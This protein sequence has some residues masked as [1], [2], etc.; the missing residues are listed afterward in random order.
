MTK[1]FQFR[2]YPTK[3]QKRE[4]FRQF[5]IHKNLYNFCLKERK[6][7]YEKTKKSPSG[8]DQI[9]ANVSKFK[10]NCNTSSLQQ[11][12]RR[13]DKSF[14]NFFRRVKQGQTPGFPRFKSRFDSIEF[15][16]GDG[17]RKKGDFT[18]VQHVG[19]IKTIFH[20]RFPEYSRVTISY[21]Q[22]RF[23]ASYSCD[24]IQG[25]SPKDGIVGIDFGFKTFV[26][27]SDGEK[28]Q[29]PKFLKKRLK[30]LKR[31]QRQKEKS[32]KGSI[33]CKKIGFKIRNTH[34]K[35]T[36][37]R[38]DWNHKLSRSLV[39]RY[40]T[41]VIEDIS[42]ESLKS[43]AASNRTMGD[44]AWAQFTQM[45]DY[46]A[47]SAGGKVIRV[48]PSYT[49]Q[50]CSTCGK[51]HD[52]TLKDRVMPCCQRLDRDVNAAKNILQKG[53]EFSD[54][55]NDRLTSRGL[56]TKIIEEVQFVEPIQ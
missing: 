10:D 18:Y 46:K 31:L 4:I 52:L 27:T 35:I 44:I 17:A 24:Y 30:T 53:F 51:R 25:A 54:R 55:A 41:I 9:K 11:T 15:V 3:S 6:T 39:N 45:L 21:K 1:T 2:L 50:D 13:L 16:A 37:Q 23:F 5:D 19:M 8:I 36:D 32:E 40:G 29:S 49:S 28:I 34:R 33:K 14:Q 22:G 56:T 42:L 20:R 12:V 7:T 43:F 47:A 48:D 26:V 38:K